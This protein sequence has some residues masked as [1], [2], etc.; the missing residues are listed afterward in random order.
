MSLLFNLSFNSFG[1]GRNMEK[2]IMNNLDLRE[3]SKII[4][5][6]SHGRLGFFLS[7][8][9]DFNGDGF[10]D[11]IIGAPFASYH[12]RYKS[13][14]SYVIFGYKTCN[15]D[16]DLITIGSQ[17][18][19][20]IGKADTDK[21]GR[22]VGSAGD[23]NKDGYSDIIIGSPNAS[24]FNRAFA[25]EAYVIF[26]HGGDH[27]P[28]IDLAQD[29]GNRGFRISGETENSYTAIMTSNAGD[30]N[31]DGFSDLA[32][33]APLASPFGRTEAGVTYVI[34]GHGGGNFPDI[35]LANTTSYSGF[36]VLGGK[37]A[38]ISG[39]SI[40]SIIDFN[41]DGHNDL[42]IGA[43]WA[44]PNNRSHA[45]EAY[46]I[47]GH[48]G[49]HFPDIDLANPIEFGFKILGGMP[50]SQAGA[51]VSFIGDF[52]G[53]GFSDISVG[54]YYASPFGRTEAGA[55]YIIFGHGGDYF[56]DIDLAQGLGN[57]G[58][59]IIGAKKGDQ[60]GFSINYVGDVNKD[61]FDDFIIGAYFASPSKDREK[62]GEAYVIFGHGGDYFPDIDLTQDLGNNGFKIIGAEEDDN[63]GY[64][65][66]SAGDFNKDGYP[67]LFI[68]SWEACPKNRKYAGEAYLLLLGECQKLENMDKDEL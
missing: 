66:S 28:D 43:S 51:S 12:D 6:H 30:F 34:F 46:V 49:D 25:G 27:F 59:K 61:G 29:L 32:V 26:G 63:T 23:F 10:S 35:D 5:A 67:D 65:V 55:T 11:V 40:S 48:G 17:G 16:I 62:A 1:F 3:S 19:R 54:A 13:G 36:R 9:Y 38:D 7:N 31:S 2:N 8:V 24:P 15:V 57:N 4:G 45:G 42:I 41:G 68:S 39:A 33:T 22:S 64:A 60:S 21:S 52:N 53:D 58:F 47:F 56:P 44:S 50:N 37:G 20:I 18:F 14:I